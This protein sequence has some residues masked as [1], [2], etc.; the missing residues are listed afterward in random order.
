MSEQDELLSEFRR[1]MKNADA[2]LEY[3]GADTI[4]FEMA[5]YELRDAIADLFPLQE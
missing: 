2:S 4:E 3:D 1:T 5:V